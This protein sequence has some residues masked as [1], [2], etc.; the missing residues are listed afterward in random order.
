[1]ALSTL[2]QF[3]P[4][5]IDDA[6]WAAPALAQSALAQCE[7]SFVTVYMWRHRYGHQI[8]RVE[9]RALVMADYDNTLSFLFPMSAH[10]RE[11]VERLRAVAHDRGKPLCLYGIP[12]A[13]QSQVAAAFP[14]L[15]AFSVDDADSDYIYRQTDLA[16][17]A[18]K[19][20]QKKR[21]HVSAFS[22]KYTWRYE[23]LT[24]RNAAAALVLAE[25][26]YAAQTALS[27]G[28]QAEKEAIPELLQYRERLGLR[29]G[30]LFADD[31]PV[32]FSLASL[33]RADTANVHIEKALADYDGAYAAINQQFV[34]HELGD[35]L[36]INREN[37][38]GL[39][40][41][42][43]AKQSYAPCRLEEKINAEELRG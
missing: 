33:L 19:T 16:Q 29:G 42:R 12:T 23:T 36:F 3:K 2:V 32:G 6:A 9:D 11:D 24:D 38:M 14:E 37:D 31:K 4:V 40:G 41:L 1:M 5:T 30:L 22:R 28:L 17:L 13:M 18:G 26:W 8:A 21:N 35:V 10:W 25:E 15:F 7:H 27:R 34:Q 43:K 20:Y 39:E